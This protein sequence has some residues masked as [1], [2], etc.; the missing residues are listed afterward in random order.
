MK[1][2]LAENGTTPDADATSRLLR[3]A[4]AVAALDHPNAVAIYDVGEG[5]AGPYI[6]MEL[7]DGETLR[8]KM[9]DPNVPLSEKLRWLRDVGGALAAAHD[10]GLVHRDVKPENVMVRA[11]GRVKDFPVELASLEPLAVA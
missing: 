6:V 2:L 9:G 1:V 8:A 5:A 4:R 11:D 10:R 3:E 7:V